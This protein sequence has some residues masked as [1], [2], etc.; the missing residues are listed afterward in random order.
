MP[1]YPEYRTNPIRDLRIV[2]NYLSQSGRPILNKKQFCKLLETG[3]KD[4]FGNVVIEGYG[5][6]AK[7]L[8]EKGTMNK[9]PHLAEIYDGGWQIFRKNIR[10]YL[11]KLNDNLIISLEDINKSSS[12]YNT[13]TYQYKV[14]GYSMAKVIPILSEEGEQLYCNGD[15]P[16]DG[17]KSKKE[18]SWQDSVEALLN[19]IEESLQDKKIDEKINKRLKTLWDEYC[20]QHEEEIRKSINNLEKELISLPNERPEG[21]KEK[22]SVLVNNV[23]EKFSWLGKNVEYAKTLWFFGNFLVDYNIYD[24]AKEL[25]QEALDIYSKELRFN[26]T[27]EEFWTYISTYD[28]IASLFEDYF[29]FKE[30]VKYADEGLKAL[31]NRVND[32]VDLQNLWLSL[33]NK[34]IKALVQTA[35]LDEAME[36]CEALMAFV[37]RLDEQHNNIWSAKMMMLSYRLLVICY[38]AKAQ[39][40]MSDSDWRKTWDLVDEAVSYQAKKTADEGDVDFQE[41]Q[42]LLKILQLKLYKIIPIE[43]YHSLTRSDWN[44]INALNLEV[45]PL[46][47]WMLSNN[48]MMFSRTVRRILQK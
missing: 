15:N 5:F 47:C 46:D 34:K 7:E 31:N 48:G 39:S 23:V 44:R 42:L 32:D 18:R 37:R 6:Q 13:Y 45:V 33:T 38:Y 27:N 28:S 16:L 17:R 3:A 21:W 26:C 35:A 12:R 10:S 36:V 8:R 30:C 11:P 43:I 4:A 40:S 20:E 25:Y 22:C 14:E 9:V 1:R 19:K 29:N 2:D 24:G 41:R